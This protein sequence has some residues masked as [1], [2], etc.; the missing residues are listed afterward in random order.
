MLGCTR[1]PFEASKEVAVRCDEVQMSYAEANYR[2]D[3]DKLL[4]AK[5]AS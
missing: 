5:L 2:H 3:Q 1:I 4:L